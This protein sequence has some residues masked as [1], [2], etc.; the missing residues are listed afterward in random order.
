MVDVVEKKISNEMAEAGRGSI[1][2]D[3]WSKNGMHYVGVYACYI[4]K[5]NLSASKNEIKSEQPQL[6]LLACLPMYQVEAED[7][8]VKRKR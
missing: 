1:L 3:G 2:H 6:V 8:E 7:E 5:A 4:N